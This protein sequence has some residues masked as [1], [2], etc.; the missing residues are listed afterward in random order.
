[1]C[2]RARSLR[3]SGRR[4]TNARRAPRPARQ[5]RRVRSPSERRE[6]PWPASHDEVHDDERA[7]QPTVDEVAAPDLVELRRGYAAPHNDRGPRRVVEPGLL[8]VRSSVFSHFDGPGSSCRRSHVT[9]ACAKGRAGLAP[10]QRH[11]RAGRRHR[12][13][14]GASARVEPRDRVATRAHRNDDAVFDSSWD[15]W[16]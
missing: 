14:T 13:L 2:A 11:R 9:H 1:M 5:R 7:T 10:L 12:H 6:R 16:R 15:T 8:R 3:A 4:P